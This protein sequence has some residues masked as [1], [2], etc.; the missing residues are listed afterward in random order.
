MAKYEFGYESKNEIIEFLNITN[1]IIAEGRN[2]ELEEIIKEAHEEMEQRIIERS[3][4]PE[5]VK[6]IKEKA[7]TISKNAIEYLNEWIDEGYKPEQLT[8]EKIDEILAE[9]GLIHN[10]IERRNEGE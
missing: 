9:K 6:R 5:I 3:G 1:G 2:I 7:N 8:D 4:Y 10:R